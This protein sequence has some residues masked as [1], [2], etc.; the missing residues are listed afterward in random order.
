MNIKSKGIFSSLV[1]RYIVFVLIF[2]VSVVLT[3][4]FIYFRISVSASNGQVPKLTTIDIVRAD[5]ENIDVKDIENLS[6]WV[7]ILDENMK[8]IFVLGNKSDDK[9][10]YTEQDL[11]NTL[12]MDSNSK[13][14]GLI[15]S[16]KSQE[17]NNLYCLIKYP[18]DTFNLQLNMNKFTFKTGGFIYNNLLLGA[19][20]FLI[21]F[22]VNIILYSIWTSK[23]IKEPLREITKGIKKMA[24]GD[25]DSRIDFKAE[26]E[27]AII[28]D[29]FNSMVEKLKSVKEENIKIQQDKIRMLVDLSHDIRT[30]ISAI[31]CFAKALSEGLIDN[32][33]KKQRYYNT[34]YAKGERV[35]ELIDDLFEFVKL[36]SLDYKL[37]KTKNDFGEF[38]KRI[39]AGF[40]QEIEDKDFILEMKIPEEEIIIE[41]D[42]KLMNRAISNIVCNAIKYNPKGTKLRIEVI[43][44]INSVIFEVADNGVGIPSHMKDYIFEPFVRVDQARKSDGGTGL[45]LAIARKI[46]EKHCG[47]L[48][49]KGGKEDEK[50][51]F[52][53]SL[54]KYE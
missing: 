44:T 42:E 49:I 12:N 46:V 31:Q 6:G 24:E 30:P 9:T 14:L 19:M 18:C 50:T 45:G 26:R 25:Y 4:V 36:E 2:I 28:M 10:F 53:I 29:S 8:V 22:T 21:L 27:F 43:K 20:F 5:Y 3:V 51:M 17:G 23:K 48:E 37:H 13:Y 1:I 7:E 35:S 41:F 34:I 16:F 15:K 33:E 47:K 39:I 32:D 52:Q 54:D 38:I 11:I 40:Y